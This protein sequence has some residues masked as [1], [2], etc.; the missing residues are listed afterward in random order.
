MFGIFL[1]D[2]RPTSHLYS[3]ITTTSFRQILE[4]IFWH[5]LCEKEKEKKKDCLYLNGFKLRVDL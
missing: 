3:L 5:L 4:I 1:P 2:H